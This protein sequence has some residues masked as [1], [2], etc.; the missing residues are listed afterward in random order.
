KDVTPEGTIDTNTPGDYTG[1]VEITYPDGSS[2]IVDVPVTVKD[3][4]PGGEDPKDPE[5]PGEEDPKDP[6]KPGA[7]QPGSNNSTENSNTS[8]ADSATQADKAGM[9]PETG[10]EMSAHI[11]GAAALSILSGLGLVATKCRK[12]EE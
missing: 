4:T 10:E 6:T 2:E 3:T 11:F 9:L 1:K 8:N 12:E 5:T 7:D